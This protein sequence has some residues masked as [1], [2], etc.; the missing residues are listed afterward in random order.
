MCAMGIMVT[1][2]PLVPNFRGGPQVLTP[3]ASCY[4]IWPALHLFHLSS[5]YVFIFRMQITSRQSFSH[6]YV[7]I[8][9]N[10][11]EPHSNTPN[12]FPTLTNTFISLKDTPDLRIWNPKNIYLHILRQILSLLRSLHAHQSDFVNIKEVVIANWVKDHL[13]FSVVG[14]GN[15]EK[16]YLLLPR[17]LI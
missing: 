1:T 8:L 16:N 2:L 4:P 6:S 11:S 7:W 15:K 13:I 5:I 14:W 3:L 10:L 12:C 17:Y 9:H